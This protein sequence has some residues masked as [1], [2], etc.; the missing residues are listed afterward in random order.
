[1][2]GATEEIRLFRRYLA[3]QSETPDIL[4]L[5]CL[6]SIDDLPSPPDASFIGIN[7][8]ATVGLVQRLREIGA[9]GATC[10]ASG[11]R[12]S[13]SESCRRRRS[14]SAIAGSRRRHAGARPNCYGFINYLDNVAMWPDQHG[15][16]RSKA[17][18]RSSPS[19]P[20]S[21]ST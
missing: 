1:V 12:E 13:E 17:A 9:G 15:A 18:S 14:S 8:E 21:R 5:P 6:A 11:F 10:F 19:P 7:R 20:T 16:G 2:S 3:G 4:G